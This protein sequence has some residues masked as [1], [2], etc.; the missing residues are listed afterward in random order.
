MEAEAQEEVL[1]S[2]KKQIRLLGIA[3]FGLGTLVCILT[4]SELTRHTG[5]DQGWPNLSAGVLQAKKIVLMTDDGKPA[6]LL[7]VLNGKPSLVLMD[8]TGQIRL[9]LTAQDNSGL[10]AVEGKSENE[11]TYI[12]GGKVY[13]GNSKAGGI[14][15]IGPSEGGPFIKVFDNSG[16]SAQIGRTYVVSQADGTATVTSAA[17]MT[18][19]TKNRSTTWSLLGETPILSPA[20]QQNAPTKMVIKMSPTKSQ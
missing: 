13:V 8:S 20:D 18:G 17:S 6:G 14:G 2:L 5:S 10:I 4:R 16:Y 3:V 9:T 12:E 15:L 7:G 19:S 11:T 1:M